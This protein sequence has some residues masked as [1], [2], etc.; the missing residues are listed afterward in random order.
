MR[1]GAELDV[2]PPLELARMAGGE[3]VAVRSAEADDHELLRDLASDFA[4]SRRRRLSL[5][6]FTHRL[7]RALQPFTAP[8][9]LEEC[10]LAIEP[11]DGRA[12]GMAAIPGPGD[13]RSV[14]RPW[15]FVREGFRRRGVG[16]VLLERL[17]QRA[18]LHEHERFRVRVVV[19][20]QRMLDLLR[21][22]GVSCRPVGGLRE[23]DADL[24][25]PAGEG[26]GVALGAALWAVARGGLVATP[27]PR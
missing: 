2:P 15:L 3:L 20:E 21:G 11:R 22:V 17:T 26:L 7:P 10:L 14:V 8:E 27:P 4:G 19:S 24:P 16:T 9:G 1:S 23:V 25:L 13:D 12:L 18:R 5:A 6:R